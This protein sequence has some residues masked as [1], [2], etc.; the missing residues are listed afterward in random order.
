MSLR[1][2][3]LLLVGGTVT[4][5]V[6][7]LSV[8]AMLQWR[9]MIL[10]DQKQQA[11]SIARALS[12]S[13]LENLIYLES[14]APRDY[15][16]LDNYIHYFLRKEP[17]VRAVAIFDT[18]GRV[19]SSSNLY[20]LRYRPGPGSPPTLAGLATPRVAIFRHPVHRWVTEVLLPLRTGNK[21]WGFLQ[22]LLEAESTR[23]EVISVFW[24]LTAATVVISAGVLATIFGLLSR[25]TNSLRGLVREM[26][27]LDP[28][29]PRPVSLPVT[30]DE[31]GTLVH[32]FN[33][34]AERLAESRSELVEAHRQIYQAEKLASIGRL[35]SGVAHEINNP[36]NGIKSCLYLIQ[37][38]P[39]NTAQSAE[40]LALVGEGLDHIESVVEKLL[41]FS[42]QQSGCRIKVDVNEAI[43]TVLS[44]L[45][46]RLKSGTIEVVLAT[47]PNLAAVMGDP[48]LLQ[49][50]MMNLL[51]N[52]FDAVGGRGRIEVKTWA[53]GGFVQIRISDN[54]PGITEE[55]LS[56]IFE[57]FFTTKEPGKGT[58]LG[59]SVALGI[60]EAHGG[61]LTVDSRSGQGAAFTVSLPKGVAS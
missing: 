27:R 19:I 31:P 59:L 18:G 53:A 20:E 55:D 2:R 28:N 37:K 6:L 26:D 14:G 40:Y 15:D 23:R 10:H 9:A 58:G 61:T 47:E 11:L 51:L 33:L 25:A 52:G 38:E 4:A 5:L 32:H 56:R 1:L 42:R 13:V 16:Q 30:S 17:R 41:G 60:V 50:V 35:A 57:P 49:E 12:A 34:L 24:A 7:L 8:L 48:L 21:T 45:S 36:L 46:Y 39:Q 29:A 22:V 43:A 54:G 3:L 44:L